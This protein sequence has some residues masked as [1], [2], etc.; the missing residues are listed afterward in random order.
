MLNI[1]KVFIGVDVSKDALDI[2]INPIGKAIKIKNTQKDIS[3]FI[4]KLDEFAIGG[5]GC[6]STGG[7]EKE[8]R[9][10]LRKAAYGL[11]VIDPRRIKAFMVS[12]GS[13]SK[14]D[15]IDA[16]HIAEFVSI[17]HQDYETIYKTDA[18]ES[19]QA[20]VN[21]RS[22]FIQ[23]RASDRTRLKH[24]AHM[25]SQSSIISFCK[26]LDQEIKSLDRQIE[27]LIKSDDELSK[28]VRIIKSVP[29]IG[30]TTAGLLISFIPELG[31]LSNR[32]IS[33]LIGLCPYENESGKYRGKK[34]IK[35]GR[36]IP[37]K[38]LYM[39]AL[40][41]IKYRYGLKE[42]YD[43]LK[44]NNK[45]FKI[46]IVAVMHKLIMLVNSLLRRSE[47]YSPKFQV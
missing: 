7:Y 13:R 23:F 6:E 27:E 21:R 5:I 35:G 31:K 3:H 15:K 17:N 29:G 46:A 34:F 18:E 32:K 33:A 37:R 20:L 36:S 42:F 25:A 4:R 41:T 39:C 16:K 45:P 26:F 14:T 1:S 22:D 11:W 43:R 47:L 38:A 40:T 12:R 24:P 8:L 30:K 44:A 28:K 2:H 19:L 9:E 10:A